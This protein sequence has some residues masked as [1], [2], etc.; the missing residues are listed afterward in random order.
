MQAYK[1]YGDEYPHILG[2]RTQFPQAT[3]TRV[4]IYKKVGGSAC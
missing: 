1:V 4:C 2:E 3:F